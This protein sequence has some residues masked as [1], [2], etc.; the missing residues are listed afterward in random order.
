MAPAK[1][2]A[3]RRRAPAVEDPHADSDGPGRQYIVCYRCDARTTLVDECDGTECDGACSNVRKGLCA[4]GE[5]AEE[6]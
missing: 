4:C 1:P 5:K 6:A 2:A 3:K